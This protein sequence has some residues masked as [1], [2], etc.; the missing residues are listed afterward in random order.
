MAHGSKN[1]YQGGAKH[2]IGFGLVVTGVVL[3]A[4]LSFIPMIDSNLWW[5][6]LLDFPRLQESIALL[7][8]AVPVLLYFRYFRKMASLALV[9][10]ASALAYHALILFPYFGPGQAGTVAECPSE[11]SLSVMI[12]NVKMRNDPEGHLVD[13][14]RDVQPDLFLA[15]E[16]NRKWDQALDALVE[17]MPHTIS[18]VSDSTFGIHLF[19]RLPLASP[20]IRFLAGQGTPQV[21]TGVTLASGE[22]V[23]FLGVHPRPPVPSQA[24]TTLGRDAV[25]YKAA[26]LLRDG[27]R[28]GV[29]AGDFN[30]TP[31]ESAVT[32]MRR[33]GDLSEPRRGYG[34]LPTFSAQSWWMSWPLDHIFHEVGF[35]TV[36]LQRLPSFGSDHYPFVGRFCR[37][38]VQGDKAAN[39]ADRELI[40]EA[41]QTIESARTQN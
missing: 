7:V 23:D 14:V 21:V 39:Q 4:A 20:K 19:S 34:Y 15:M 41:K 40:K 2:R 32:R 31:W 24:N 13:M 25:L 5:I 10:I 9:L 18:H 38:S 36:S 26:L 27:E 16:T 22:T 17:T 6:R 1:A 30:A 37:I 8:L 29:V 12:A 3:L 33:I 28:P 35:A 11:R